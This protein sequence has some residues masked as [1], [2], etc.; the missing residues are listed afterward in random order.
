MSCAW[1]A[2][3]CDSCTELD[4]DEIFTRTDIPDDGIGI[5]TIKKHRP[6][7]EAPNCRLCRFFHQARTVYRK[8]YSQH[9]R[10][11]PS[12]WRLDDRVDSERPGQPFLSIL[13]KGS[14][15]RYN[16]SMKEEVVQSG[17]I[18]Y[19][20]DDN[21][22][23]L[24][25]RE[26]G[27]SVVYPEIR[28]RLEGC[29]H[30]HS[31][32]KRSTIP[33]SALPY[34]VLIDC[35]QGKTMKLTLE[36]EYMTLS[37]VW[38][39]K[40]AQTQSL[41]EAP[42]T[43]RDAMQVVRKLGKR[44]LWVDRY[45]IDQENVQEKTVMLQNMDWIYESSLATIVAL[46]GE[47]DEAGLPGVSLSPRQHRS[48][49]K[50]ERG[51][52]RW[53]CP[54]ISAM[55]ADS[56]WNTRGWTYQ[57]ARLSRCCL[58]FS[59]HQVYCVCQDSTWSESLPHEASSSNITTL[60]N[61]S[62]LN[63][64]LFSRDTSIPSGLFTDRLQYTK[65]A[66]TYEED[67]LAAFQ[68]ILHRS[69]FT[70]FWGIPIIIQN[71]SMDVNTGFA[72]GLLWMKRPGWTISPHL[73]NGDTKPTKRR[74]GFPTWSWTSLDAEIYQDNYGTQSLYGK[75]VCGSPV[76]LPRNEADIR[77]WLL[78]SGKKTPL[79]DVVKLAGCL[80]PCDPDQKLLIEGDLLHARY[81]TRED[82]SHRWYHLL[83]QWRYFEADKSHDADSRP[84][85]PV[86][87]DLEDEHED[88]VLV[89]I[90]WHESQK[91]N[92]KRF[93]LMV[94][95]WIDDYHAE[96]LGLLTGYRDEFPASWIDQLPRSRRQF[97]LE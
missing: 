25:I 4:F 59:D 18:G 38:G 78:S 16:K 47:D 6:R 57:E 8:N 96:R 87:K 54:S 68:G 29:L 20:A 67:A 89:L 60:L 79:P 70:T 91:S 73:L 45:C 13:R 50:T 23:H 9:V 93:L 72:L 3:L 46:S 94:L 2:D 95:K 77:F 97:I 76:D 33:A 64:G 62:G 71:F 84:G 15:L 27:S 26:V 1:N 11:F 44:Y 65:R 83:D 85:P 34:I 24:G 32:C 31:R 86:G 28:Q 74:P 75:Y 66:L 37:Y 30:G 41:D 21:T 92:R 82:T 14:K 49:F 5:T 48:S 63:D 88:Y 80:I 19:I 40:Q 36:E 61:S 22:E 55:L 35:N 52:L 7:S 10:L 43:I 12:T 90:Q 17:L 51:Y 42:L 58:F 81:V 39:T 53:S 69:P 56:K